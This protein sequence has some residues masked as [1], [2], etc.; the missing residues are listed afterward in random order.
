[1]SQFLA[2]MLL[3]GVLAGL[4]SPAGAEVVVVVSED[5]PIDELSSTE[6][7]DIYLGRLTRLPN[8][9]TIRP[10]DQS[11]QTSAHLAFY[12][13]YLDRTP[14][15]IRAHWSRLIFTGRGQPPKAVNGNTA[16]AEE[17][18]RNPNSIGYMNLDAAPDGLRIVDIK[19]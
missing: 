18:R 12:Q 6:L 14:A 4:V 3:L 17:L 8:G 10:I 7:T 16:M 15:Q 19:P 1:M 13:Q 9:V 5:S 2:K 11:E